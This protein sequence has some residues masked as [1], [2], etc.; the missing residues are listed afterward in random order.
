MNNECNEIL[1]QAIADAKKWAKKA[2]EMC[3]EEL[4]TTVVTC[5][6]SGFTVSYDSAGGSVTVSNDESECD[7]T[8]VEASDLLDVLLPDRKTA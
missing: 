7:Y 3:V 5:S 2:G 6:F 4:G 1:A 8:E